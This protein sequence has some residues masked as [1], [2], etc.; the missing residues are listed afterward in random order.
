MTKFSF[1]LKHTCAQTGARVGEFSTPH[2]A[3]ETPVFMPVGTQATVKGLSV[4]EVDK[5][6]A[7]ILLS[8]TYHLYMRPGQE[9]VKNAGGLHKFMNWNKPILT[10]SGGFQVFSL[11]KL[12]KITDDGVTFNSH[13]DGS[14]HHFTPESAT[15]IQSDLGADIFMAFDECSEYGATH[16]YAEKAVKRTLAWLERCKKAHTNKNQILFPI[17][18]GN[19]FDDLREF[20]IKETIPYAECGIAVGGLSVGEPKDEMFKMLDVLKPH[21]PKNMPHY[22]MGVGSPDC[23]VE[24]IMRGIDMFDCVL[25]TRMARFGAAMTSKGR[26]T[27]RNAEFKNDHTPVDEKCDCYACKSYSKSYIRHLLNVDEILGARLLSIH[28]IHYLINLTKRVKTAILNNS[29]RDFYVEFRNS[30]EYNN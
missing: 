24:A 26:L 11:A 28:N 3:I 12:N 6:G 18:Q 23:I 25:P 29:L 8:N 16:E 21:Y 14:S 9:I 17:V 19:M 15:Q 2:G 30:E 7:Q 27:I 22:L 20:S 4:E 1:K 5:T 10:D 13:I